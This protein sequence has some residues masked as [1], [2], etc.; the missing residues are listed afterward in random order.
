MCC[1]RPRGAINHF[2]PCRPWRAGGSLSSAQR[3]G[4]HWSSTLL[5]I[6]RWRYWARSG[7]LGLYVVRTAL[8]PRLPAQE[9]ASLFRG[10]NDGMDRHAV[11][12]GSRSVEVKGKKLHYKTLQMTDDVCT[13]KYVYEGNVRNPLIKTSGVPAV[14]NFVQSFYVK[15]NAK[16]EHH[17]Q[18]IIGNHYDRASNQSIHWHSDKSALLSDKTDIVSVSLGCAGVFCYMPNEKAQFS[19]VHQSLKLGGQWHKRRQTAIDRGLRGCVPL[20]AGDV[21]LMCGSFQECMQHR[22]L[23]F[24]LSGGA[25]S[26]ALSVA[27]IA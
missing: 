12:L 23:P 3:M 18:Q 9:H 10:F 16:S 26:E 22:T 13:C 19:D 8:D 11:A 7:G 25:C 21:L 17:F 27:S 2:R 15:C 4:T 6:H 14:S 1:G 5:L 20:F 24:R